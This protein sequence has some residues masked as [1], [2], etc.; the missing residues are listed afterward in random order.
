VCPACPPHLDDV[1][2]R[3]GYR[4]TSAVSLQVAA[5][6]HVTRCLGPVSQAQREREQRA[7]GH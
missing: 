4:R 1:L 3:R 6:E 2:S 5:A 7:G